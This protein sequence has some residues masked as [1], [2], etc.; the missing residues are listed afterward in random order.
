[1]AQALWEPP[2]T[3]AAESGALVNPEALVELDGYVTL[4]GSVERKGSVE[5]MELVELKE[6]VA[7]E[8]SGVLVASRPGGIV[9]PDPVLNGNSQLVLA[10]NR[11]KQ[12]QMKLPPVSLHVPRA[13]QTPES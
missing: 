12:V 6:F 5:L 1:M 11:C 9:Q 7:V 4:E 3:F 2:P 13:K 10:S 8:A